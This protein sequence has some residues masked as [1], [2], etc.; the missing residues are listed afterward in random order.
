MPQ[1]EAESATA[2]ILKTYYLAG[3]N[4]SGDAQTVIRQMLTDIHYNGPIG[5]TE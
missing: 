2:E 3:R 5:R 4:F 1:D